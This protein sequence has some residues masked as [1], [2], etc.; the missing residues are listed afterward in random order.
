[1]LVRVPHAE[2]AE[3]LVAGDH[4]AAQGATGGLAEEVLKDVE[5]QPTELGKELSVVAK[6]HAQDLWNGPDELPVGQSEQQVLAEVLTHQEG[7]L[8][9]A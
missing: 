1:M 7:P 9:H 6:E 4:G 2:L 5:G 3:C 8:L